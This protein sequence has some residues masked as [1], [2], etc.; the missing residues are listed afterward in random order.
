MFRGGLA[1]LRLV[2]VVIEVTVANGSE[3]GS[4]YDHSAT[5]ELRLGRST[6]LE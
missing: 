1:R 5:S 3:V 6:G 2:M 4:V